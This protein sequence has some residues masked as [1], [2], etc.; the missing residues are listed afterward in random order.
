MKNIRMMMV[1]AAMTAFAGTASA[2]EYAEGEVR[3]HD[4]ARGELS[5]ETQAPSIESLREAIASAD[6]NPSRFS[7]L[8]EYGERVECY[9]CVPDVQRLLL[10]SGNAHVRESAAWWLRRRPFAI[11]AVMVQ[12]REVLANDASETRRQY[13][14]EALGTL[15]DVHAVEPL[16]TAVTSDTAATVRAAAVRS[17]ARLNVGRASH[18]IAMALGDSDTSVQSAALQAIT[19]IG[20]FDEVEPIMGLL[21]STDS[22][23]RRQAAR[24]TGLYQVTDSVPALSAMLIGDTDWTV[25]QAAA[26]AL[27]RIGTADARTALL[28][29]EAMQDD[30]RVLDAIRMAMR[31][32]RR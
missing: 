21:A 31:S 20:F 19:E 27:G 12:M 11:G 1:V 22:S 9:S 25:R 17:L 18:A 7:S 6:S 30:D 32:A 29:A 24:A 26:W 5:V 16:S 28:D 4:R 15:M 2:Q 8:L 10:S 3:V 14:A 13:A 23:I